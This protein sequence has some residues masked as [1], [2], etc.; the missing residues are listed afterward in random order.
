MHLYEETRVSHSSSLWLAGTH[1]PVAEVIMQKC[2][3]FSHIRAPLRLTTRYDN[4]LNA[5]RPP[6]LA[7]YCTFTCG[8]A[9]KVKLLSESPLPPPL[10]KVCNLFAPAS[11]L[12]MSVHESHSLTNS[13]AR[14]L[15]FDNVFLPP[16]AMSIWRNAIG[17][18]HCTSHRR[19]ECVCPAHARPSSQ[20]GSADELPRQVPTFL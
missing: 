20:F 16:D 18:Y 4:S 11:V 7:Y 14:S 1:P 17:G 10:Q 19:M 13:L 2:V 15:H 12:C 5:P 9:V 8:R 3:S 6:H